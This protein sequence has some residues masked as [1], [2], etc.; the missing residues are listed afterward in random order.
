MNLTETSSKL[1]LDW[2]CRGATPA[3]P[4]GCWLGLA[5]GPP[6]SRFAS[7]LTGPNYRRESAF[8]ATAQSGTAEN[9]NAMRW[10]PFFSWATIQGVQIWDTASGG[11]MLW[12]GPLVAARTLVPNDTFDIAAGGLN[13]GLS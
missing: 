3:R 5:V 13:C 9:M 1:L 12:Q 11:Q 10:G 7:E 2:L 6:N 4:A 8:F